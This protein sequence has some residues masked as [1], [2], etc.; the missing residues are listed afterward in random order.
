MSRSGML[1]RTQVKGERYDLP[2]EEVEIEK[3]IQKGL[4]LEKRSKEVKQE[5]EEVK[6][7]LTEIAIARRQST[8]TVNLKGVSGEALVTFR[9][10]YVCGPDVENLKL[11][12]KD[13]F[14]RFF[15]EKIEFSVTKDLV[16]FL[17]SDHALGLENG[18]AIKE[19]ILTF[20]SKKEIKPNV[21]ITPL[22]AKA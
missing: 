20:L 9:E 7:R 1:K 6:A 13:L 2:V 22:E 14:T 5:L 10:S 11:E 3:L 4:I 21:K 15:T 16:K 8:T 12:L 17:E 18:A 19:Q